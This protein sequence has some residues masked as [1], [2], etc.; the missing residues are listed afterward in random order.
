M[1]PNQTCFLTGRHVFAALCA[2]A[3]ALTAPAAAQT[4]RAT[5]PDVILTGGKIFTADATH[6]WAEALAIRGERIVAVG[7]SDEIRQLA[8]RTTRDISLHGRVVVPGLNDAH[9]HLGAADFGASFT[10]S[11]SPTPEPTVAVVLDSL[12]ALV[13]RTPAG[14]WLHTTVGT[15]F[16]ED[17]T[18][19]RSILD[20]VAPHH[21]VMLWSWTGHGLV[22]NSAALRALRVSEDV[23]APVGGTYER[24][25]SGRLTGVLQEY[26]QWAVQRRLYSELPQRDLVRYFRR[27]ASEAACMGI[28]SV[29]DM[30]GYLDPQTTMRVLREAQL[31]I[32]LRVIPYPM[33]NLTGPFG[34]EWDGVDAHPAP[35][36]V[37]SG[38]KWILDGTPLDRNALMRSAYADRAGWHGRLDFTPAMIRDMLSH[39]L[40]TRQPLHLHIVG[41]SSARLVLGMMQTL[42]PDSVWRPLRVRIEHGDGVSG[43]LLPV[44]KRLGVV[45]VQN[46]A[47]FAFEPGMLEHRFGTRPAGFQDVRSILAAGIPLAIGSDGPRNP[48]LN[49]MF[50]TTHPNNPAEALTR[51]QAVTAYTLGSAFAEF[52]ERDKGMLKAGMLADLT[53]LS[54]DIFTVPAPRLPATTSILTMVGGQV[55]CDAKRR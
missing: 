55:V 32:R 13:R 44:A 49:L 16:L 39:A 22:L 37:I 31:P 30:N 19:G 52:A 3:G 28:T 35:R 29:Q 23:R 54:Q 7:T 20:R 48:F 53:V 12:R 50:A 41:D 14:T 17:T 1:I 15:H 33:T 9:D 5:A 4:V 38:V 47:H 46:P 51:E 6:P 10:T 24:D 43:D 26:A 25:A 2:F 34:A 42:A 27:N 8:T 36:T 45:I 40:A 21:P 18:V 11:A